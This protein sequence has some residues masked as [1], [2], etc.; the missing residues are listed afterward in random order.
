MFGLFFCHSLLRRIHGDEEARSIQQPAF[1]AS[2][3]A[4]GWVILVVIANIV[5]RAPSV[6]ASIVAAFIP[7][8]LCLVPAQNYVNAVTEKRSP[9]Q[10]FYGWSSG[11]IICLVI[12]ILI[13]GLLLIALGAEM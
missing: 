3:L 4:T 10:E 13:W 5:G 8:F 12:G 1:S 2:G 9:A 7:S 11:H 6:E